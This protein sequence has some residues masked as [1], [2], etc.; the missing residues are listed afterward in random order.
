MKKID[1]I[2]LKNFKAFRDQVFQF[3][4]KNVLIY[5]NNGSGKSSLFWAIYTF[6]QSSHKSDADIQKYFIDLD[7]NLPST[8]E[9]LKNIWAMPP[10]TSSIK[11]KWKDENNFAEEAEISYSIQSTNKGHGK[12][13]LQEADLSSDFISYKVLHNFF[14]TTHKYDLNLWDVFVK[15][16]F[17]YF[18]FDK[19]NKPNPNDTNLLIRVSFLEQLNSLR[20]KLP[21]KTKNKYHQVNSPNAR[22]F[23]SNSIDYFNNS[24]DL[25]L[26]EIEQNANQLIKSQFYAN[27]D[28]LRIRLKYKSKIN[29][30]L[31]TESNKELNEKYLDIQLWVEIFDNGLNIWKPNYRPHS[32]L[33]ESLLTRIA[34]AIRVGALLTRLN[35]EF[36]VLCLDDML[37][38]LDMSNR[39]KVI[40]IFLNKNNTS[41]E[42]DRMQ[43]IIFTHDKAFF[44]LLKRETNPLN[45]KYFEMKRDEQNVTP[46]V[47]SPAYS[48]FERAQQHL[49]EGRLEECA[50]ML[51]KEL[52]YLLKRVLGKD[53]PADKQNL[54]DKDFRDLSAMLTSVKNKLADSQI[55]NIKIIIAK[56]KS[57]QPHIDKL[58]SNFEQD[59]TL[60]YEIKGKL[61]SL[62]KEIAEASKKYLETET[63]IEALLAN[64]RLDV[65]FVL[66]ATAH[67]TN[68]TL[69]PAELQRALN[70]IRTL[71]IYL[72]TNWFS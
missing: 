44:N 13:I 15:D 54:E 42:F 53:I 71:K 33:N 51:R 55:R 17:P 59:N 5:G 72:E 48:D 14:N 21:R 47:L 11:V 19:F 57:I 60:T 70:N 10:E 7:S 2:H 22:E 35:G 49:E 45:W 29:Y 37:L 24:L 20:S 66:N 46:P 67:A 27:A 3:D 34:L 65:D 63:D 61:K 36:Q 41:P 31:L 69:Y 62:R 12:I 52:E 56:S 50:T 23:I 58:D 39:H 40:E 43:K 6:L 9:S 4:G 25:F 18:G 26:N 1:S 8:F 30:T 64:I 32:F 68:I 38:S 16:I 28:A